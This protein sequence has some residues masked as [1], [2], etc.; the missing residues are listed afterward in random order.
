MKIMLLANASPFLIGYLTPI[1]L[2]VVQA[3]TPS[4]YAMSN[5]PAGG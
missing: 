5:G 1:K 3:G 2:L 4:K